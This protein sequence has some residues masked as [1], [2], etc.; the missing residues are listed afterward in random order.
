MARITCTGRVCLGLMPSPLVTST[1]PWCSGAE[2]VEGTSLRACHPLPIVAIGAF[3]E[4]H[5]GTSSLR[6]ALNADENSFDCTKEI[7]FA[8]RRQQA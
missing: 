7:R 1:M 2:G 5:T 3:L 8:M 4:H 6:D